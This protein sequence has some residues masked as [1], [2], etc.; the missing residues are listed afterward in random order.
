[1]GIFGGTKS[2]NSKRFQ[3]GL[4]DGEEIEAT[5]RLVIDEI[6]FTNKRIIFY[7]KTA[8]STK[9]GKVSIPYKSISSYMI[10]DDGIFDRDI[11]VKILTNC[12]EFNLKF[13]KGENLT[14]VEKL[15]TYYVCI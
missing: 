13:S 4:M 2:N 15:L 10:E 9:K 7:D 5:Y 11:E 3:S 14:E 12:G 8:F 6:C 1:M